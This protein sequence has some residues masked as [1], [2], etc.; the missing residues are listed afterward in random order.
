MILNGKAFNPGELRIPI[1]LKTRSV[2]VETGGFGVPGWSTLDTVLA[3]WV[4]VHGSETWTADASG[5]DAPATVTV[6][7]LSGLDETCAVEKDS[8]LY[9][10]VS[11]DDIQARHEYIEL[12]VKR[13]KAG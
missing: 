10:I 13:M 1:T 8:L 2:S 3:K 5:A 7:Y 12:K 9:E 6:R 4:N 11:M